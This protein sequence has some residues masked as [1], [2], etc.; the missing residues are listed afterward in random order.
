MMLNWETIRAVAE[1][2]SACCAITAAA[3][4][5]VVYR[6]A[7]AGDLTAKMDSGDRAIRKHTD[8]S[9]GE[10]KSELGKLS[11]RMAEVENSNARIEENQAHCLVGKDLGPLHEKIN[12]IGEQLAGN[13]ATT[14]GV[15][16]QLRVLHDLL[17]RREDR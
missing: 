8:R 17:L 2:V 12:R 6:K 7:K 4:S 9:I 10:V 16:E 15:R 11:T 13:T 1:V 14:Q 5:L 3:V